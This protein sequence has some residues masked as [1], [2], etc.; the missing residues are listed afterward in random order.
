MNRHASFIISAFPTGLIIQV[1]RYLILKITAEGAI[2]FVISTASPF[3]IKMISKINTIFFPFFVCFLSH[4]SEE[5]KQYQQ[6]KS[7]AVRRSFWLHY[8]RWFLKLSKWISI[9][10]L[11][12]SQSFRNQILIIDNLYLDIKGNTVVTQTHFPNSEQITKH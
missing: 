3:L 12:Y 7:P 5:I 10:W 8:I 2:W 9:Y 4:T 1:N 11:I 6:R